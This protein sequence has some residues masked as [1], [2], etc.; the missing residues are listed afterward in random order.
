MWYFPLLEPYVDHVPVMSDLSDLEEKIRWCRNNDEKCQEI[1]ENAKKFYEKYVARD[2]LL[3]YVEM[4]C[5]QI[6][7]RYVKPPTWWEAPTKYRDPPKLRKPD[8]PCYSDKDTKKSRLCVKCQHK[9][10]EEKTA[11]EEKR[12][13]FV[14]TKKKAKTSRAK[15]KERMKQKAI[16]KKAK[17]DAKRK[18]SAGKEDSTKKR[19]KT[20]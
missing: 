17:E 18:A 16:E 3:D 10:D 14:D 2:A 12:R 19:Q 7:K 20:F 1:G 9:E 11:L 15:L 5:K 4:V 6:S 8:L 13:L